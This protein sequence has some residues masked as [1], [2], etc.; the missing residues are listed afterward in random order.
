MAVDV[1]DAQPRAGTARMT[2][3][4][5]LGGATRVRGDRPPLH[6]FEPARRVSRAATEVLREG[7][8]DFRAHVV[9]QGSAT[10][11]PGLR[12]ADRGVDA[13]GPGECGG[14][15]AGHTAEDPEECV[16]ASVWPLVPSV[17]GLIVAAGVIVFAGV[18]LTRAADELADR[19]GLG[20][21]V[22]GA[23]LLGA[24]TS[25]PG[26]VTTATGAL[27]G[28]PAYG[29][30]NPIGGVAIQTV[31]L[32]I[33]DLVYRRANLE[34]AAASLE[35][36]LQT[37]ILVALLG[38]PVI[39]YATPGLRWGWIH[40]LT[41]LIPV[42]YAYGLVLLQRMHAHPMWQPTQTPAT[43]SGGEDEAGSDASTRRLWMRL[44]ALAVLVG[45][46]GWAIGQGGLGVIAATG[47]PSGL[48]GF[49][50]TTALTSLP[51]LVVL[52][53]AVRMGALTLGVGNIIGGN[54]FDTLM[55]ALADAFY[56]E[57]PIYRDAG[58]VSLVLLGGTILMTTVLAGGLVMRD[59]KG[60]GFEGFALPLIYVG[61][62][63]LAVMA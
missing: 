33:A 8:L 52:I 31:W 37:L 17:I 12:S 22:G 18:R 4:V 30:A 15:D 26:I 10:Q 43:S 29:L 47:L 40:P 3:T 21:A 2:V 38:V 27:E 48:V 53:T 11:E 28:D 20:D 19:T 55:I 58:P 13:P 9:A 59:R 7:A 1:G 39:A 32:A 45:V 41:L 44:A 56:L 36:V 24:A 34:H 54:V 42:L 49:T 16:G 57:G 61:T 35:N 62:V 51:E 63:V 5:P 25:L 23:L 50:L 6:G 60:I 14:L 46:A